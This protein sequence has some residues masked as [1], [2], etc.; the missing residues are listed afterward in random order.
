MTDNSRLNERRRMEYLDAMG[1][2]MFVPRWVLPG[3]KASAQAAIPRPHQ[4]EPSAHAVEAEATAAP[5]PVQ[6][7]V[8]HLMDALSDQ[9]ERLRDTPASFD[10]PGE[11][12]AEG[13]GNF[14]KQVEATSQVAHRI[15]H[16][17]SE[18]ERSTSVKPAAP[19]VRS[20]PAAEVPVR[21]ALSIWR[22]APGLMILDSRVA[23]QALPTHALLENILRAKGL[24]S[25]P[26]NP[27]VLTWP[28]AGVAPPPGWTGA[29][30]M[31]QAFL[32]ARLEHQPASYLWLMGESACH[33][34]LDDRVYQDSLGLA[35][36]VDAL[37][38][39]AV[40]LRL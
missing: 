16:P 26:A 27:D 23:G 30:E 14:G 21:F 20:E 34:V 31:L 28:P 7:A 22:P 40:V 2:A 4:E 5:Q 29:R 39:L 15:Q 25:P 9:A 12:S 38:T 24:A 11:T 19:P 17:E 10:T 1:I 18:P 13:D 3:A 36:N 8:N 33:A 35:V 32:Q 37:A 6:A